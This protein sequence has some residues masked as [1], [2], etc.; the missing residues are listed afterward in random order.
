MKAIYSFETSVTTYMTQHRRQANPV[1]KQQCAL[2]WPCKTVKLKLQKQWY[3]L[4]LHAATIRSHRHWLTASFTRHNNV[5]ARITGKKHWPL[6]ESTCHVRPLPQH[7]LD[8]RHLISVLFTYPPSAAAPPQAALSGKY[9][10]TLPGY[11]NLN[12]IVTIPQ[13]QDCH[14]DDIGQTARRP[15]MRN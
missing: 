7:C 14:N 6:S 8:C 9:V 2:V 13:T 3:E 15:A 12:Y 5:T 1:H 4:I 10:P 11:C